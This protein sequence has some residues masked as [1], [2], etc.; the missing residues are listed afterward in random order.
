MHARELKT[1]EKLQKDVSMC[2]GFVFYQDAQGAM[3]P[4]R[5]SQVRDDS[6]SPTAHLE[7]RER[8]EHPRWMRQRLNENKVDQ[9]KGETWKEWEDSWEDEVEG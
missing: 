8:Q 6:Y 2:Y 3:S 7:L 1:K 9:W 5:E 4:S